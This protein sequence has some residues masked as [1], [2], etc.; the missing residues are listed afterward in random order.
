MHLLHIYPLVRFVSE[1]DLCVQSEFVLMS[2][3]IPIEPQLQNGG[4]QVT[5]GVVQI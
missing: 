2:T 3:E 5:F 4:K 1:S